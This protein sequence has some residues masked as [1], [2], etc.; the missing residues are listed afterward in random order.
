MFKER[1]YRIHLLHAPNIFFIRFILVILLIYKAFLSTQKMVVWVKPFMFV[2]RSNCIIRFLLF[3]IPI[4]SSVTS[5]LISLF[6][7]QKVQCVYFLFRIA[8]NMAA[9]KQWHLSVSRQTGSAARS[10]F[11]IMLSEYI[12]PYIMHCL[13]T[14]NN[15]HHHDFVKDDLSW[16]P[17]N[18]FWRHRC[19]ILVALPMWCK[20]HVYIDKLN[21]WSS[22]EVV[23]FLR[24]GLIPKNNSNIYPYQLMLMQF[25]INDIVL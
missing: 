24:S 10:V 6:I 21:L 15:V 9:C 13:Y 4:V 3:F 11:D 17:R 16:K 18:F 8:E 22:F 7:M 25:Y 12:C 19:N 14:E 23:E 5:V 20:R 1:H 2:N